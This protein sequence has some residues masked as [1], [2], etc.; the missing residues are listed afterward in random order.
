MH[1]SGATAPPPARRRLF[2]V[3]TGAATLHVKG[4][5]I[6][7]AS[8]AAEALRPLAGDFASTL[9]GFG[10]LGAGLLAASVVPL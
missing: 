3:V 10:F 4:V 8:D 9:F 6:T 7:D 2:V 1:I 5:V